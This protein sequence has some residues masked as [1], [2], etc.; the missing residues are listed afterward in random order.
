MGKTDAANTMRNKIIRKGANLIHAKGYNGTGLQEIL[1]KAGVPKGSFY[2][3]FRSKEDFG[4]AVID[5]FGE[6][7]GEFFSGVFL[8]GDHP[9]EV[10]LENF[11]N[12]FE[13]MYTKNGFRVGCPV[14][15]LS[16][17]LADVNEGFSTRLNEAITK[18]IGIIEECLKRSTALGELSP[19]IDTKASA[20][21]MFHG[22]EGALMHMKVSKSIMPLQVFR[23]CIMEYLALYKAS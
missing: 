8:E 16:L 3:Y 2:F 12:F 21:F 6:K 1:S 22:F 11:F 18:F 23:K 7:L 10:R 5:Y 4:Y 19:N 9:L 13:A 20:S 14:G 17:E 15:N